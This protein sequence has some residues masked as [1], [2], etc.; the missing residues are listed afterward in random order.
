[1]PGAAPDAPVGFAHAGIAG[2]LCLWP[3]LAIATYPG[4]DER[5]FQVLHMSRELLLHHSGMSTI[6]ILQGSAAGI[7]TLVCHT[8]S[9]WQSTDRR[10]LNNSIDGKQNYICARAK[11][12]RSYGHT[13]R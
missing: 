13:R 10:C 8:S 9:L 12:S 6:S 4:V 7:L 2:Q 5:V 1:M 11:R 3:C